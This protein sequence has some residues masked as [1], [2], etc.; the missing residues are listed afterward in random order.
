MDGKRTLY[1]IVR[2]VSAEYTETKAEDLLKF[3]RDLEK[4]KLIS[5]EQ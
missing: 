2:A 3:M 5:L 1:E 4:M